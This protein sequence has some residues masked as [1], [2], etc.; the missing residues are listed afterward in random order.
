MKMYISELFLMEPIHTQPY[1]SS[2]LF[3]CLALLSSHCKFKPTFCRLQGW[4]NMQKSSPTFRSVAEAPSAVNEPDS[5]PGFRIQARPRSGRAKSDSEV[6]PSLALLTFL[7]QGE[8]REE[9]ITSRWQMIHTA[10][11]FSEATNLLPSEMILRSYWM[12]LPI[13]LTHW[14]MGR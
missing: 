4:C 11:T 10:R 9:N 2:L 12:S 6:L 3:C 7:G 5:I 13:F 8:K 14:G 1:L